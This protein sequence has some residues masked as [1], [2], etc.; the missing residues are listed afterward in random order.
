MSEESSSALQPGTNKEE[1]GGTQT[2]VDVKVAGAALGEIVTFA[3]EAADAARAAYKK[4]DSFRAFVKIRRP[5]TS[6]R[7]LRRGVPMDKRTQVPV[8]SASCYGAC[9]SRA[10]HL[11]LFLYQKALKIALQRLVGG[12]K[13]AVAMEGVSM[14]RMGI[15]RRGFSFSR[16]PALFRQ[17]PFELTNVHISWNPL[18][19]FRGKLAIKSTASV[20]D[21]P[22]DVVSMK[23]VHG[24]SEPNIL[25]R[26]GHINLGKT[27]RGCASAC[28]GISGFLD[29]MMRK[30]TPASRP[31]KQTGSFRFDL[32]GGEA[33]DLQAKNTPRLV[34]PYKHIVI[35]GKIDAPG[36]I[37]W[38]CPRGAMLYRS[39]A[40]E[41]WTGLHWSTIDIKASYE[42]W[43]S[44]LS[45]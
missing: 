1:K 39:R 16:P 45:L 29:G 30:E 5:L 22:C 14:K 19:L 27:S 9:S 4:P 32:K 12:G 18:S 23:P 42:V 13:A 8:L 11:P 2:T 15:P 40:A 35:E 7:L 20:Y 25:L 21:A 3:Q 24:P 36:P 34:I 6:K 33:K 38:V 10:L 43:L 31:D 37:S 28:K 41:R 17:Y 44:R 26:L